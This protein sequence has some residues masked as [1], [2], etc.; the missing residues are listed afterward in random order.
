MRNPAFMLTLPQTDFTPLEQIVTFQSNVHRACENVVIVDDDVVEDTEVFQ[1]DVS[2][3]DPD[4]ILG[5]F[6][7]ATI[8]VLDDDG[9][10]LYK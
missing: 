8:T 6:S 1:I 7:S 9:T 10:V 5:Q 3:S 2:S 4:V